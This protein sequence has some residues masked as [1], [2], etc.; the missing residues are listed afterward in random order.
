[1]RKIGIF[2]L[3]VMCVGV[4]AGCQTTEN[5]PE[6]PVAED[7]PKPSEEPIP[8]EEPEPSEEPA[9]SEEPE[10]PDDILPEET[11]GNEDT[12]W[13]VSSWSS[14]YDAELAQ[15]Q[16]LPSELWSLDLFVRVDG[17]AKFRDIHEG[18][19]LADDSYLDL[20][21][22]R[23]LEG[24]FLFY[25]AL[26]AEPVLRG[27]CEDGVFS[28]EY[29]G[30]KLTMLQEQI[31]QT[32]GEMYVPAEL[33]GTWLLVSGETETDSWTVMP[34]E[35]TS[36]VIRVTSYEGPLILVADVEKR[37]HE[38]TMM[39]YDYGWAV[40]VSPSPL[41]DGCENDIW[42]INIGGGVEAA[43]RA[44]MIDENILL[45]QQDS[46]DGIQT[47]VRFSEL[48]T[49]MSPESMTLD[50]TNWVCTGYEDI[51][52]EELPLPSELEGLSLVLCPDMT[53]SVCFADGN[54]REGFWSLENGGVLLMHDPAAE[55]FWFGGVIV[56]YWVET[57][58]ESMPM[59]QM[60]VYY[61]GGILKLTVSSYG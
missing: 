40:D 38:G 36:I 56:G 35:L 12:Y 27:T 29:F 1:M 32:V 11:I 18:I 33:A 3:A 43:I 44:T 23:T 59:Y 48:T 55:S 21:W 4:L 5:L 25:S 37:D 47:Y 24:E 49:W 51:Y 30:N 26:Y 45:V 39:Q 52:G 41:Y 10:V 46:V 19:C 14:I 31:P 60:A 42:S 9:P 7:T 28:L 13:V 61:N 50:Y 17:T 57:D 16:L 15:P 54:V 2:L 53:C 8:P 58:F 6:P 22:E 34:H 20:Y